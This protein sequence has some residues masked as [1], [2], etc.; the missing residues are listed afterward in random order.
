M[1]DLKLFFLTYFQ[2]A[3]KEYV[4]MILDDSGFIDQ[5]VIFIDTVRL[6][7]VFTNLIGNAVKFTEKGYIRF[8]YRQSAPDQLEFVVEDTGIGLA[9]DQQEVIFERFRQVE[10]G[11]NRKYGGTGLGLTITRSLVQLK[12]GKIWVESTEG[13]GTSFFFTVP[14]LPVNPEDAHIFEGG[15]DDS[16][17]NQEFKDFNSELTSGIESLNKKSLSQLSVLVVEPALLKSIYYD[18][19]ISATGATVTKVDTLK[20]WCNLAAQTK[21][22]DVVIAD[23][24]V[25]DDEEPNNIHSISS[26][27]TVLFI[28]EEKEEYRELV[29]KKLC[30]TTVEK[31]IDFAKILEILEYYAG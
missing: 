11:T 19:L 6:R 29:N 31:P 14:Y 3:G 22:F 17:L 4:D 1:N 26:L 12:G 21:F 24:S 28:P 10:L 5:C 9:S 13:E 25:F 8:G 20:Q 16:S 30:S 27:P 23:A 7:Q 18:K 15:Y 2:S